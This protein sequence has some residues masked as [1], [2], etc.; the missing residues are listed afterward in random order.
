MGA[1]DLILHPP[2]NFSMVVKGI[3]RSGFPT[4]KNF[5]FLTTLRLRSIIYMC[6]EE[7]P[8]ANLDFIRRHGIKLLHYGGTGNKEPFLLMKTSTT[9]LAVEAATNP[10]NQPV[11][12]HC[13]QGKHRTGCVVGCIRK[14]MKWSLAAI[15]NE[16]RMV[17]RPKE[18]FLDE[19]FIE[20]F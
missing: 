7:Y 16:Y 3:Y 12:I 5:P 19:Q 20:L 6:E 15:F 10:K 4:K 1:I 9:R 17:S 13:N 14:K 11:L 8:P 2:V 18:R